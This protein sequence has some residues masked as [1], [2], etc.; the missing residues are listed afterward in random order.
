MLRASVLGAVVGA[1]CLMSA[2][3]IAGET[4]TNWTGL[5]VGAHAGYGWADW[6]GYAGTTAGHP[7]VVTAGVNE[8]N[9]TLSDEGFLGGGQIG[10][11]L[12]HQGIVF[13]IEGDITW[14]D[15][16][17]SGTFDSGGPSPAASLWRKQHDLTLDSFGTARVR[18]GVATGAFLPY[19]TG[20]LAWGKTSGDLAVAYTPAGKTTPNG[21]SYASVD[22]THIG[23]TIGGGVEWKLAHGW[24]LKAEYLHMDLGKEDYLFKGTTYHGNPANFDTDSFASDLTLDTVKVGLNYRFGEREAPVPLK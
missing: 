10:F 16:D 3:A 12:Q 1:V 15:I 18:V 13:G 22:E 6:D 23:W 19:V 8:P 4:T 14:A 20:G 2:P 24:S 11:N 17:A 5:Y 7:G 21:T 9:Q